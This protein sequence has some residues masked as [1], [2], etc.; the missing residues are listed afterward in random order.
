[1]AV[2][3][4]RKSKKIFTDR[5]DAVTTKMRRLK[6]AIFTPKRRARKLIP[7]FGIKWDMVR[8]NGV[9]RL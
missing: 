9:P 8:F 6:I 5:N 7:I 2:V 3:F 4:V 1:M